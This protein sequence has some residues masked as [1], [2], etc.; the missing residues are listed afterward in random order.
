VASTQRRWVS[1]GTIEDGFDPYAADA[2]SGLGSGNVKEG[3]YS[4]IAKTA[5]FTIGAL[6]EVNENVDDSSTSHRSIVFRK[7]NL[8][9]VFAGPG[10]CS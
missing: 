5:D 4:S 9:W 1:R 8:P 6:V 3:G 7:F 10:S 2:W